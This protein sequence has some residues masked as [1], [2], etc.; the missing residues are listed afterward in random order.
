M[1]NKI[2]IEEINKL[3]KKL[4]HLIKKKKE[5]KLRIQANIENIKKKTEETIKKIKHDNLNNFL[6]K[7]SNIINQF[8]NIFE[9]PKTKLLKKDSIIQGIKLIQKSLSN[10]LKKFNIKK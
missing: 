3:K 7:L 5:K 10:T 2:N 6:K 4:N 1:L 8:D 9:I